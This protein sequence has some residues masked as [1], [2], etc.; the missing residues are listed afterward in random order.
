MHPQI[1]QHLWIESASCPELGEIILEL[2]KSFEDPVF[3]G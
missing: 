3:E 2:V 1:L